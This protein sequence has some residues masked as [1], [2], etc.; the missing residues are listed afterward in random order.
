MRWEFRSALT[1][2]HQFWD[3]NRYKICT[4]HDSWAV[5]ACGKCCTDLR[6][7]SAITARL[8]FLRI[9]IASKNSLVKRYENHTMVFI[10]AS[11]HFVHCSTET[12]TTFTPDYKQI[13]WFRSTK[14]RLMIEPLIKLVDFVFFLRHIS[15]KKR[16]RPKRHVQLRHPDNVSI[17]KSLI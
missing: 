5:V 17:V 1:S 11:D 7:R 4:C 10:H 6:A 15:M 16:V 12:V 9:C 2:T 3:S 14:C 13:K 8:I